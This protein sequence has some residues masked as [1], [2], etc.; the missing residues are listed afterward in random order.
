MSK[1]LPTE[2][3]AL[4]KKLDAALALIRAE[5]LRA[6]LKHAPMH[7]SHEAFG[8]IFE[9]FNIE[10]AAEMVANDAEKQAVEMTQVGAM[11]ARA[12]VDVY[13]VGT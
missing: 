8:V 2:A 1:F 5:A 12:L 13:K 10:F 3:A 6:M 4:E 7:S 11:A 9:E